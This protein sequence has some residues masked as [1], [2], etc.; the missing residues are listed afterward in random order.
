MVIN[1]T[2]VTGKV[3][4]WRDRVTPALLLGGEGR[5]ISTWKSG[6]SINQ[7]GGNPG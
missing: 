6:K 2:I 4:E 1:L 5:D 7:T 3:R